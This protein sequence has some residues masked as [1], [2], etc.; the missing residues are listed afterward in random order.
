MNDIMLDLET[1]STDVNAVVVSISAVEFDY[2]TGE[3]GRE[4]E[5]GLNINEQTA[6]GGVIDGDTVMWW[7]EQ[8]D[9]ARAKLLNVIS[10]PI[11]DVLKEFNTFCTEV[12]PER[13]WGNGSTFDNVILRQLYKR[14]KVDFVVPFW[15]D[16]DVR[17]IVSIFNIDKREFVFAGVPH[18]GI[19]DC[20]FQITYITTKGNKHE[21]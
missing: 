16:A 14:C 6:N 11:I 7:L 3:I 8:S 2:E 19:D 9:E 5:M 18:N 4:F 21:Y 10:C 12:A 15:A 13:L 20:K 17:T 1:F